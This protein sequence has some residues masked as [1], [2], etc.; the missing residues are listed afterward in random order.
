MPP[1]CHAVGALKVPLAPMNVRLPV[2]VPPVWFHNQ[3]ELP[4]L[5]WSAEINNPGESASLEE[6]EIPLEPNAFAG[7]GNGGVE[8]ICPGT[9]TY[10]APLTSKGCNG[11]VFGPVIEAISRF[12]G[13]PMPGLVLKGGRRPP[14]TPPPPFGLSTAC[15]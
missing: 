8:V 14:L 11:Y 3:I 5:L 1:P 12:V 7:S 15:P 6:A 9:P 13:I 4:R 2:T 10:K